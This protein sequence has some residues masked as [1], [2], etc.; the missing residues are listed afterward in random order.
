M[1]LH[2]ESAFYTH[3]SNFDTYAFEYDTHECDNDTLECDFYTQ[4]V[5]S[6][7]IGILTRTNMITIL[8]TVISE[9]RIKFPHAL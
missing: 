5:I 9:R 6:T 4:S 1:I 2:A 8:T 3:E 7:I